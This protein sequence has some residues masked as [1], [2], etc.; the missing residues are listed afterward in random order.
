MPAFGPVKRKDLIRHL[1]Q[2]GFE[3]PYSGGKHQFMA[4][5]EITIRVP[6]PHHGDI[7]REFLARI[8]RQAGISKEEWETL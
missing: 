1:K 4:R 7:G 6:N 2:F 8:L 5:G 3:G